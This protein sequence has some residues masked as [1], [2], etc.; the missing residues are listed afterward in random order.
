MQLESSVGWTETFTLKIFIRT[1]P[2]T[3]I[4][5]RKGW[6]NSFYNI[7]YQGKACK[8]KCRTLIK[9]NYTLE[10]SAHQ[11]EQVF[12]WMNI[13]NGDKSNTALSAYRFGQVYTSRDKKKILEVITNFTFQQ[14]VY[15]FTQVDSLNEG[16]KIDQCFWQLKQWKKTSSINNNQRNY[17]E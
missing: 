10:Y 4:D 17:L 8:N 3:H 11:F 16:Y 1:R 5:T 15:R 6:K 7:L 13:R 12:R 14:C 9:A 2:N